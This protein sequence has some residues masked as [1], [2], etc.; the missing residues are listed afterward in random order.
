MNIIVMI[1]IVFLIIK[2]SLKGKERKIKPI[3][4]I[5]IPLLL[6]SAVYQSVSKITNMPTYYYGIFIVAGIIGIFFGL[7]R[8]KFYS[9]SKNEEG[10]VVYKRGLTD[11]IILIAYI[12]IESL[13][14]FVFKSYEAN[15][16]TLINSSLLILA[17]ASVSARRVIMFINYSKHQDNKDII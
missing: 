10:H 7:F 11:V 1:L 16:F 15:L 4:I 2:N 5:I 9:Y 3:S 6:L 8:S 12:I 17:T 13:L 14:R